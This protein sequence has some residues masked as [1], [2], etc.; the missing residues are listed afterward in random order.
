MPVCVRAWGRMHGVACC[1]GVQAAD[2]LLRSARVRMLD[3]LVEG[4]QHIG[5]ICTAWTEAM[6]TM[7]VR[8]RGARVRACA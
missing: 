5:E 2:W 6:K 7:E 4:Q 1:C 8:A 3:A